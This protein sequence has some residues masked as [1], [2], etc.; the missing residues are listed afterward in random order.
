MVGLSRLCPPFLNP[1]LIPFLSFCRSQ[2]S[3]LPLFL[4]LVCRLLR[5]VI[6]W[7][8]F[9]T[10]VL[11][12]SSFLLLCFLNFLS[13]SALLLFVLSSYFFPVFFFP[14][15]FCCCCFSGSFSILFI[16]FSFFLFLCFPD[17]FC[18]L[19]SFSVSFCLHLSFLDF[20]PLL[21]SSDS[22]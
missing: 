3:S 18:L 5:S 12:F 9:P 14:F 16:Y 8:L 1:S 20:F 22:V 21:L 17:S 7:L 2:I 19:L 13:P 15:S 10:S 6:H 4:S 11:F